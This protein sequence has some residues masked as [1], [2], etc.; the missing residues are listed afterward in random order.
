MKITAIILGILLVILQ[1]DLWIGE[2][3]LTAMWQLESEMAKQERQN[4]RL[5]E[6]NQA[7]EAEVRD[8][9]SG[10]Q[11]VEE[12]ARAELGMVKENETFYQIVD[13]NDKK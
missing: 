4:K 2:G 8:L 10:M 5:Q 11:A 9:K 7:L 12:R 1:V 3:S 13:D 6:R